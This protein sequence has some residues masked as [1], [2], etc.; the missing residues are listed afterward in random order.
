MTGVEFI[1]VL[2]NGFIL[3]YVCHVILD[4]RKQVKKI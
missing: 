4:L 2:M 1:S 3:G